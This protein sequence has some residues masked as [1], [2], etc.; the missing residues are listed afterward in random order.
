MWVFRVNGKILEQSR[1]YDMHADISTCDVLLWYVLFS[2][3]LDLL[4]IGK[5]L[6]VGSAIINLLNKISYIVI[7]TR[8][9]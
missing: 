5:I 9:H 1:E 3:C 8:S 4:W 2:S 6:F 7:Q